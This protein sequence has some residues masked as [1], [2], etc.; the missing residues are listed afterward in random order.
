MLPEGV[1]VELTD[2]GGAIVHT[3]EADV[4]LTRSGDDVV[5]TTADAAVEVRADDDEV[6]ITTAD[7]E[8]LVDTSPFVLDDDVVLGGES[9]GRSRLVMAVLA[10]LATI[11]VIV[12]FARRRRS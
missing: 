9:A 2:A 4:E 6:V 11:A 5:V 7:E 3:E 1:S 12:L 10:A 8:I